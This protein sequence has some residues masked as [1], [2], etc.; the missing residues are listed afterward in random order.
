MWSSIVFYTAFAR[1][2]RQTNLYAQNIYASKGKVG[3]RILHKEGGGGGGD[4][5]RREEEGRLLEAISFFIF[6]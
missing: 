3:T 4:K 5:G 6:L 2:R 1:V